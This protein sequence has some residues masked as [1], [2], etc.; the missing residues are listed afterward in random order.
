MNLFRHRG[1][2]RSRRHAVDANAEFGEFDRKLF[3]QMRQSGLAGAIGRA[4]RRGAQSRDRGN[5]DDRAAAVMA[6]QRHR[7]LRAQKRPVRLTASTR[8]QSAS[9]VS[10][11]GANTA[12][13]A[14]L[15]S[16][17]S[18]P[19]RRSISAN[20][21][22]TALASETSQVRA[23][24][25]SGSGERRHAF[26]KRFAENIE[27]RHAPAVGEKT[28]GDGKPDAAG[29]ARDQ[30][31]LSAR[32]RSCLF[33]P[34]FH[35]FVSGI[36]IPKSARRSRG[37]NDADRHTSTEGEALLCCARQWTLN[38]LQRDHRKET[39]E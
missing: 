2:D 4:Q 32:K 5:V 10:I 24:V 6:H 14:L 3:G 15:I 23:S 12:T 29:S 8:L 33:H 16:A 34:A 26:L 18:R 31:R 20:A 13:P 37:A 36:R 35:Q 11:N 19:K 22:A 28:F 1:V 39:T 9:D 17:S 7:G 30:E 38:L 21:A 25:A 27:Q